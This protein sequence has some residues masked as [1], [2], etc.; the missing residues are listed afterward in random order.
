MRH[1]LA[2]LV[3]AL[4]LTAFSCGDGD[5]TRTVMAP[6]SFAGVI[7]DVD[8]ARGTDTEWVV[9]GSSRLVAQLADGASASL[10]ITADAATMQRAVDDGLVTD[11]PVTIA[12]NRLVFAV[13]PGNPGMIDALEDL[14]EPG[15]VL[16]VC[17]AEVPCGRL[18]GRA[19]ADLG[20]SVAADTE[21]PNVRA[22]ALKIARGE[23]DGG[24]VYATDALE[25]ALD[26]VADDRLDSFVNEYQAAVADFADRSG[27]LAFLQSDAGREIL[28]DRGFGL[29]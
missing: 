10:L 2:A 26:T 11:F 23:L 14:A 27:V 6:S 21:E 4:A 25:F 9:A 28:T 20:L 16:G 12:T 3:A 8:L 19:A 13:A 1:G 18:A 7:A 17:A 5:T 24:L 15:L 22:L 29:P